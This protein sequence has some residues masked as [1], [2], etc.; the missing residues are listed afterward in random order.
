LYEAG[1][2]RAFLAGGGLRLLILAHSVTFT[3]RV[4]DK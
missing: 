4:T 3:R 2:R 1:S